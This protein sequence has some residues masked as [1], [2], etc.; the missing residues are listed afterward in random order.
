MIIRTDSDVAYALQFIG[1]NDVL[2]FDTETT[3]LDF[4]KNTVIGFGVSTAS[5]GFYVPVH[6]WDA[7]SG[8]L[9]PDG[10]GSAHVADILEALQSKKLIMFNASFDAR[11]T[12]ATFNIDLLPALETDVLLLKHTCDEDFPLDLKGI[13][14]KLFGAEVK[15]EKEEMQ[16]SIRENGGTA[17]EYYKA[18]VDTLAKYCIQDCKLTWRIYNHYLPDLRR[19]GLQKF[20]YEDEVMPL[21]KEVVIPMECAGVELDIP[22]LRQIQRE[23]TKDIAEVECAIQ[24]AIA[25]HLQI[26]TDWFL[27]KDYPAYTRTGKLSAWTKK[28]KNAADAFRADNPGVFMFNL[29]SKHHLKKLFFDTLNEEPLSRTPTGQPQVNEDFLDAMGAKHAWAADLIVYNKL[30]KLKGTYIDRLLEEAHGTRYYPSFAMHRTVSGRLSG[31]FQQMPRPIDARKNHPLVT[32]YT[33]VIREFVISTGDNILISADYEQLEPCIFSHVSNDRAL[34]DI[35]HQGLDFYSEIAIRTEH[36]TGVSSVKTAPNFL[37]KVD[38]DARQRAKAYAL[39]IAYGLTG[40]KLQ[41]ELGIPED[42]ANHLVAQYLNAFPGL[43]RNMAELKDAALRT[44]TI[45]SQSGRVRRLKRAKALFA[46]YGSRILNGLELWRHMHENPVAYAQAKLDAKE[47]KNLL[48]S[49]LNFPIQSL[50]AGIINRAAIAIARE[51]K[52]KGLKAQ[53]ILQIHDQLVYEVPKTEAEQVKE[54]MQR[55]METGVKLAVPLR[56]LP[57]EATRFSECK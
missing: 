50:A 30:C 14:S 13:A 16:A 35:F 34:Q 36:L 26:F 38:K 29:H 5:A 57:I 56:A 48:N 9:V 51:L 49:A 41:F 46:Q 45:K 4:N 40:Y 3:G 19:Q 32:K 24:A 27:K 37:G 6:R 1:A 47:L 12:L 52:S 42:E 43:A 44:G 28:H 25:P 21:Y 8:S 15:L 10:P 20:F 17:T 23:I 2:A 11:M 22:K 55:I 33:N 54:I 18:S 31:D 39:G 53:L 7:D